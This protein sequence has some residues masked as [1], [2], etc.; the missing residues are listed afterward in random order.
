MA[1]AIDASSPVGVHSAT[2]VVASASFTPVANATVVALATIGNTTTGTTFGTVTDSVG[3]VWTKVAN[4]SAAIR[5]IVELWAS[6]AGSSPAARTVTLTGSGTNG[7]S[8]SLVVLVLTGGNPAASIL[9]A[10]AG[11]S[12]T[13]AGTVSITATTANSYI[14]VALHDIGGGALGAHTAN[15]N[16]TTLD[17]YDDGFQD[18]LAL[19][20]STN[21]VPA[22]AITVGWTAPIVSTF[23]S[24][25]AFEVLEK[26]LP[27]SDRLATWT[28]GTEETYTDGTQVTYV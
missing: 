1:I 2:T 24:I 26:S 27:D 4:V 9:G 3:S 18:N 10:S 16:T 11:S 20:R 13:T 7:H 14:L 15:A 22:G 5:P 28:D 19:G 21:L 8:V 17:E 12:G 25:G 23:S 6:D